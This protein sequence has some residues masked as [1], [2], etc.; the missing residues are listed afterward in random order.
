MSIRITVT[1]G[2]CQG[3]FHKVGDVLVVEATTPQ[4]MCLGA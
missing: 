2:Q 4:G 1:G 3:G